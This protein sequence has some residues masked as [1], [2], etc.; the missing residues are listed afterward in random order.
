ME[1]DS[2]GQQLQEEEEG[3]TLKDSNSSLNSAP[4]SLLP[5]L[6]LRN[7][8][9]SS[10]E[11]VPGAHHIQSPASGL[12]PL[13]S[14]LTALSQLGCPVFSSWIKDACSCLVQIMRKVQTNRLDSKGFVASVADMGGRASPGSSYEVSL[15]SPSSSIFLAKQSSEA[16]VETLE[17]FARLGSRSEAVAQLCEE[18]VTVVVR[19]GEVWVICIMDLVNNYDR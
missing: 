9:Q 1:E 3:R 13:A 17:A 6:T 8:Y 15:P 11:S 18:A 14:F 10:L 5:P 12:L 7:A 19:G 16:V 4:L 2:A